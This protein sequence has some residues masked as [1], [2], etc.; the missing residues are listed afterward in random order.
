MTIKHIMQPLADH[1]TNSKHGCIY[2]SKN[3]RVHTDEALNDSESLYSQQNTDQNVKHFTIKTMKVSWEG[4][5]D[6]LMHV[7][8]DNTDI[9]KLEEA[10]NSIRCQKIMFASA[11]HEF[12][13]P[14]NAIIN[15]YQ[16]MDSSIHSLCHD[17]MSAKNYE[18]KL[19]RIIENKRQSIEKFLKM[20]SN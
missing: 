14:L 10:N 4:K 7:F 17:L 13:T 16:F 8:I 15:S 5:S 2:E 19:R 11:S 3:V 9:V 20:G 12:R 6:C 18:S 1:E